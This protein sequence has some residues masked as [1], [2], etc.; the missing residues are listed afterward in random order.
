[1]KKTKKILLIL[2]ILIF[3]TVFLSSLPLSFKKKVSA[4]G[5]LSGFNYRVKIPVNPLGGGETDYQMRVHIYKGIGTNTT[6][7]D[8]KTLVIYLNNHAENWPFDIRFT[9]DDGTTTIPFWRERYDADDGIWWVKIPTIH[10]NLTVDYYLYYG[11]NSASDESNGENTFV[12]F[13]DFR[14][15]TTSQWSYTVH[16]EDTYHRTHHWVRSLGTSLAGARL[17]YRYKLNEINA[18]NWA[19]QAWTGMTSG[20]GDTLSYWGTIDE[21]DSVYIVNYYNTDVG[22]SETQPSCRFYSRIDADNYS[23]SVREKIFGYSEGN[24]YI[25]EL[26][27]HSSKAEYK[28]W[29]DNYTSLLKTYTLTSNIPTQIDKQF[30]AGGPHNRGDSN[31]FEWVSGSPSYLNWKYSGSHYSSTDSFIDYYIYWMFIGK[32]HSP[33]PTWATPESEETQA[34]G[35]QD[36]NVQGW[37]WSERTGWISFSCENCDA[38]FDGNWDGGNCGAGSSIDYGVDIDDGQGDPECNGVA[39]EMCGYAWSERAG[40]IAFG[41]YNG[42]GIINS[43]DNDPSYPCYPNCKASVDLDGGEVSGWAKAI[44]ADGWDGWIHLRDTNYGVYIDSTTSPAE[45][46]NWARSDEVIGWISFNCENCEN[47]PDCDKQAACNGTHPDYK[48]TT[49]L[50]FVSPPTVSNPRETFYYCSDS[51]HPI[52]EWDYS[53]GTSD[54]Y[55]VEVYSGSNLIYQ[56]EASGI[57]STSHSANYDAGICH[58]GGNGFQNDPVCDFEYNTT[59]SWRV[60]AKNQDGV[61]SEWSDWD[62]FTTPLHSFPQPEFTWSPSSPRINEETQFTDQTVF[63]TGA[64]PSWSWTIPDAVYTGGTSSSSQNPVVIFQSSGE[65]EVILQATDTTLTQNGTCGAGC[66]DISHQVNVRYSIP[67]WEEVHPGE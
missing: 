3:G 31:V 18:R 39:G 56:Y 66:C 48:V 30:F 36:H 57:S 2:T 51:L 20:D 65:K 7:D 34:L 8:G 14:S 49:D 12:L 67:E 1:M 53:D 10:N 11:S 46:K 9:T 38:D 47:N 58:I 59:Y 6:E 42:D 52:L 19:S 28:L 17:R 4:Q 37:A 22:A 44:N 16:I 15:D 25:A 32:Y 23:Y 54:G 64:S 62:N 27:F 21:S 40:Y 29:E 33:E 63:G 43:S 60:K 50:T 24:Y 13:D 55:K 45:F 5:W 35:C 41:D 61:W 26:K